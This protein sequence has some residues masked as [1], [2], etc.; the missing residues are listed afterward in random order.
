M[1]NSCMTMLAFAL[2]VPRMAMA[3]Q[4]GGSSESA[5]AP[6]PDTS[7]AEGVNSDSESGDGLA[8]PRL[9]QNA[10][11]P[12]GAVVAPTPAPL[13][14][15][16]ARPGRIHYQVEPAG[17]SLLQAVN[18][19]K[20][21]P[22]WLSLKLSTH[23][24]WQHE[25]KYKLFMDDAESNGAALAV[26][27]RVAHP[28]TL[29]SLHATVDW[30]KD[31]SAGVWHGQGTRLENQFAGVGLEARG[32]MLWWLVPFA[33]VAGGGHWS[34]AA[35]HA[36]AMTGDSFAPYA[37]GALGASLRTWPRML[38]DLTD[39]FRLSLDVEW[40]MTMSGTHKYD[41]RVQPDDANDAIATSLVPIGELKSVRTHLRVGVGVHF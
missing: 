26:A 16:P 19:D 22:A 38:G 11:P 30:Q 31:D 18:E 15:P 24:S 25:D 33:R 12:E 7:V 9:M 5:T 29:L 13:P 23:A 10:P 34:K 32:H 28:T 2:L 21:R 27:A 39:A 1:K 8:E 40:G 36:N 3:Q 20:L 4:G 17:P 14:P 35:V 37:Q 6:A 41:M